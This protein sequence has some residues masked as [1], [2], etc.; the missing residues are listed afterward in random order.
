MATTLEDLQQTLEQLQQQHLDLTQQVATAEQQLQR[1][2]THL[3]DESPISVAD[4]VALQR[5]M[6]D[7]TIAGQ[8]LSAIMKDMSDTFKSVVQKIE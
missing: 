7:Y 3:G 6:A 2:L 1:M 4:M 5:Q 8:T